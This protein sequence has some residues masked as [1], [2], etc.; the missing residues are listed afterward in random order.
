LAPLRH[1]WGVREISIVSTE[2]IRK[3]SRFAGPAG[4]DAPLGLDSGAAL[5]WAPSVL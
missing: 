3:A 4:A 1:A 2:R 5:G